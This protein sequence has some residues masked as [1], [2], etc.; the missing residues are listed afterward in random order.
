MN[1]FSINE[2]EMNKLIKQRESILKK[3]KGKVSFQ[4]FFEIAEKE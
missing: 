4:E 3:L 2:K 1:T